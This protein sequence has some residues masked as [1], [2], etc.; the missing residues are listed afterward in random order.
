MGRIVVIGDSTTQDYDKNAYPQQGWAYYL[1]DVFGKD[2]VLNFARAGYALKTYI[3]AWDYIKGNIREND[4][5]KC[6]FTECLNKI[7]KGDTVIFAWGAINDM[8]MIDFDAYREAV[9]GEYVKDNYF[10]DRDVFLN[11]GKGYGTHNLFTLRSTPQETEKIMRFMINKIK[12]KCDKVIVVSSTGKYYPLNG[13][14]FN[15]FC[16]SHM[17]RA[18]IKNAAVTTESA[19]IDVAYDFEK[20]FSE[21]GYDD[22][23]DKYF[24]SKRT[25]ERC[26]R[27]SGLDVKDGYR[28]DNVHYNFNGAKRICDIFLEQA[29]KLHILP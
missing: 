5:D 21:I 10:V 17:Y 16:A 29:N 19:Y 22:M 26:R 8:G 7:G 23:M 1:K 18:A 25:Y 24:L 27:E 9:G 3:Y 4:P 12:E 20:E 28:D 2:N 6:Y 14:K 15:V 11:V 13:N